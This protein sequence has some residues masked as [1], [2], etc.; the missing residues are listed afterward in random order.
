VRSSKGWPS[1]STPRTI[2]GKDSETRSLRRRWIL[3][4]VESTSCTASLRGTSR[5]YHCRAFRVESSD[6]LRQRSRS[7]V[8][9]SAGGEAFTP[10][11]RRKNCLLNSFSLLLPSFLNLPDTL[12]SLVASLVIRRH[13]VRL[14]PLTG[15]FDRPRPSPA[16]EHRPSCRR[17]ASC[18]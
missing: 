14:A 2:N 3:N 9:G 7:E 13:A 8:E 18:H 11:R 10:S 12:K 4:W 6:F 1:R 16:A 5:E 15:I 17:P